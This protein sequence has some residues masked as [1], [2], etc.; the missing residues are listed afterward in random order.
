MIGSIPL[1]SASSTC[2]RFDRLI[3][4]PVTGTGLR[5]ALRS[6]HRTVAVIGYAAGGLDGGLLASLVAFAPSFT[7]ILLG[8]SRFDRLRTN[9]D[10]RRFLGG[11]GPAAIGAILGTAV[12][13]AG[14]LGERWQYGVLAAAFIVLFVA[15]RGVVL[16][17]LLA[18]AAGV[19]VGVSGGPLPR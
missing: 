19:V 6:P 10:A 4:C 1:A 5:R 8:A 18:G 12:P 3:R 14:A 7:F 15:R 17:L 11:A 13:L 2:H 9:A 16:T